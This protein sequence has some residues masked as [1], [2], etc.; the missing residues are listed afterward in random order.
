MGAGVQHRKRGRAGHYSR[1]APVLSRPTE[2][3]SRQHQLSETLRRASEIAALK[4]KRARS[5]EVKGRRKHTLLGL[6]FILA[7]LAGAS[8]AIVTG[9]A[10]ILGFFCTAGV[11]LTSI[12]LGCLILSSP[13]RVKDDSDNSYALHAL[14]LAQMSAALKA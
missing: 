8:A 13:S 6:L 14:E 3:D 5:Q 2:W 10:Q 4:A 9:L 11:A 12:A 7:G 1:K